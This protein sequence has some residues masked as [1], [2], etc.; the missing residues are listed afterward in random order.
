MGKKGTDG[1]AVGEPEEGDP[2]GEAEDVPEVALLARTVGVFEDLRKQEASREEAS[3]GQQGDRRAREPGAD[4]AAGDGE[5]GEDDAA[6][7]DG[8]DLEEE[9]DEGGEDVELDLNF[10][11]PGDKVKGRVPGIDE[12]M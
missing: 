11:A 10:K 7:S 5:S 9:T 3:V 8:V 2:E 12:V 1:K 4:E 6:A